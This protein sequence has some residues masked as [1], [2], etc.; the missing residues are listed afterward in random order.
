MNN[1]FEITRNIANGV[2]LTTLSPAERNELNKFIKAFDKLQQE[3]NAARTEIERQRRAMTTGDRNW[4]DTEKQL[5]EVQEKL[6][7]AH[8]NIESLETTIYELQM[9]EDL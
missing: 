9:G 8:T 4:L 7:Q 3:L 2:I 1:N 6:E 5:A